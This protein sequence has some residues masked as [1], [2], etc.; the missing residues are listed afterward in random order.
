MRPSSALPRR[1][2]LTLVRSPCALSVGLLLASSCRTPAPG[3]TTTPAEVLPAPSTTPRYAVAVADPDEIALLQQQFQLRRPVAD[4]GT[5]YFEADSTTL[6]RLRELGYQVTQVDPEVV[7]SR[8]VRVIRRGGE[9]QLRQYGAILISREERYWIVSARLGQLRRMARE[10]YRLEPI[11][12]AEPRP[13]V[14]VVDVATR[15][16]VQRVANLQVDIFGVADS[17]GRFIIRG[18]ALDMQIDRLREAGF[19][20]T[21]LPS[22]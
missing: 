1:I 22:P 21:V 6:G 13:R 15:D 12:P 11:G 16:D 7:D 2:A 5:L 18:G 3:G 9:E 4:R 20:V 8:V 10:G 17:A 19:A 14:I